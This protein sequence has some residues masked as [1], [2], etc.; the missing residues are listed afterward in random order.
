MNN[1]W[2]DLGDN[3]QIKSLA[4]GKIVVVAPKNLKNTVVPLFCSLCSLPMRTQEDGLAY[5]KHDCCEKCEMRWRSTKDFL[6]D[7]F[8]LIKQTTEWKEYIQKRRKQSV[9]LIKLK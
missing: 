5:K 2:E 9:S 4:K 7:D 6:E 1:Q 3:T 8:G